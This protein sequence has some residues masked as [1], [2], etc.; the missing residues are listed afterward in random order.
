MYSLLFIFIYSA[1]LYIAINWWSQEAYLIRRF[2][3]H[4]ALTKHGQNNFKNQKKFQNQKTLIPTHALHS[5]ESL[6]I[7]SCV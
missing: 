4:T 2:N 7:V 6:I 1:F 5:A 3:A